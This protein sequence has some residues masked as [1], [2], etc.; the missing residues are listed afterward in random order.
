ML[1]ESDK[2]GTTMQDSAKKLLENVTKLN[3]NSNQTSKK[4]NQTVKN[5]ES[6]SSHTQDNTK[7]ISKMADFSLELKS[8]AIN[9]KKLADHTLESMDLIDKEIK[10]IDET[11]SLIDNIAFQTNILS[12]NAAV[13][14]ATAGD[15]GKG[16]AV[17]ANEV[18]NLANKT[19]DASTKIK[20]TVENAIQ[21]AI[22][23]KDI[24]KD[25][26]LG[27]ENLLNNIE[28]TLEL[29]DD[30]KNRSIKQLN[31]IKDVESTMLELDKQTKQNQDVAQDTNEIATKTDSLSQNIVK[32]LEEKVY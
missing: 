24:T 13:E 20:E 3:T 25:M 6:I 27:Y 2:N 1:K 14:A 8:S 5:L 9:G 11:I 4:L 7:V 29:V 21:R 12:L 17:V 32:S 18:R 10:F 19:L 30:T 28:Q 22:N 16:F 23:G 26:I 31:N 15:A